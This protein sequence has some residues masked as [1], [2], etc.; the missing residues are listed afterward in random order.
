LKLVPQTNEPF[1]VIKEALKKELKSDVKYCY[2]DYALLSTKMHTLTTLREALAKPFTINLVL[3]INLKYV[4]F[5]TDT[6]PRIKYALEHIEEVVAGTEETEI[7]NQGQYDC[8][9]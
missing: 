7:G 5:E 9:V 1:L 4:I 2:L 3:T 6:R 8:C